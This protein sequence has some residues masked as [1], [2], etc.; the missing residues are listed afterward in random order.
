[1]RHKVR[2]LLVAQRTA[3]L[4]ALRGHMAE[5]G[6]IAAQGAG[7]ARALASLVAAGH[8]D[9]PAG[10]TEALQPLV[11]QI[12]QLDAASRRPTRQSWPLHAATRT[13]DG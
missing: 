1:M 10:V 6:I 9:V 5:V 13:P 7:N 2:E 3:L 12:D 8:G 11:E 4:N